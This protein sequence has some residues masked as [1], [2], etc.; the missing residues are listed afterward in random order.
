[1]NEENLENFVLDDTVYTTQLTK[2][3][4]SR[5]KYVAPDPK[6]ILAYIPGTIREIYTKAGDNVETGDKMLILEAMKMR[7]TVT[8]PISG[9]VKF[10][11][12][13]SGQSVAKNQLLVEFE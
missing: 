11:A 7:N 4:A 3:F 2:K 10:I 9:K 5:K 6:K 12:V 1:M 8:A 13:S